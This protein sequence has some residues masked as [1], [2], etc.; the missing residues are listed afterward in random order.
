VAKQLF[1]DVDIAA[2][3]ERVWGVLTDFA[4][5]PQWNPFIV[6][7][8]GVPE[9]GHRLIVTMQPVGGRA[10]TLHPRLVEVDGPRQLRWLGRLRIPGLM[11]AS[12]P[13]RSSHRR[14]ARG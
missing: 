6:R 13:S 9:Q 12:T 7:A 3:P 5:Y 1:A 8:E 4:A 11:D 14:P 10:M 2:T